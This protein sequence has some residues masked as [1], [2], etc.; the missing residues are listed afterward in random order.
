MA[1]PSQ[2]AIALAAALLAGISAHPAYAP[3]G[4]ITTVAGDGQP[5]YA[6]D[7][8]PALR[9]CLHQPWQVA[10]ASDGSLYIAD[11]LNHR[12]R[13]ITPA[14]IITTVAGT[15]KAGSGGDGR[16]ATAARLSFPSSV[17]IGSDGSLYIAE[18]IGHRIRKV[19][20]EGIITIV[21]GTSR[22][23]YSGDG[24]P[25]T[26]AGLF[27]PRGMALG[28]DGSIYVA[29]TK[30]NRVRCVGRD[31]IITTVAGSG[32]QDYSGD[33]GPATRAGLNQ[34]RDVAVLPDGSFYIADT[35][36][37]RVRK[38]G[39]KGIIS[40]V[41]GGGLD[42]DEELGDG[43][44]ATKVSLRWPSNVAVSADGSLL[45]AEE[46]NHCV[47]KVDPNGIITTVAGNGKQGFSG[48]GGP[49]TEASLSQPNYV[50]IGPDGSLY[51][52]DSNNYRVRKVSWTAAGEG[53]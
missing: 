22:H 43:V 46:S 33:G 44:P 28:R 2:V 31:G 42:V 47:R 39:A 27:C 3:V 50:A 20:P 8:G 53:R 5:Q 4:I 26:Q 13:R 19:D 21:A 9:A 37:N 30:N 41:A 7:G 14:G 49:A 15:A 25:A 29:D 51:I 24:G 12:I 38:V 11:T 17:A 35:E 52:A 36:N 18:F 48:D 6:G 1:R 34:P 32:V 16:P 10:V 40:T 23:G 45:I